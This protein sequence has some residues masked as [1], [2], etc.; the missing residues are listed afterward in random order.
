MFSALPG[1]TKEINKCN[2][3][4]IKVIARDKITIYM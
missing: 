3:Y 1:I 2:V 4:K